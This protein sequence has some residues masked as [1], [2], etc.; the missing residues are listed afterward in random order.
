MWPWVLYSVLRH[1]IKSINHKRKNDKLD[2]T[3]GKKN[4]VKDIVKRMKWQG[5]EWEKIFLYYISTKNR[6]PE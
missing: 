5:K 4:T 2:F 1:T 3:R 6:Y